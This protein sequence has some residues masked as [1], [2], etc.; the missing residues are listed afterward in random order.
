MFNPGDRVRNVNPDSKHFDKAGTIIRP[1]PWTFANVGYDVEYDGCADPVVET[2][3]NLRAL[4]EDHERRYVRLIL[5]AQL[6]REIRQFA[7]EKSLPPEEMAAKMAKSG[8]NQYRLK[9]NE[10]RKS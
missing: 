6:S 5:P 1:L 2:E 3:T 7:A 9:S 4:T 8:L 10:R